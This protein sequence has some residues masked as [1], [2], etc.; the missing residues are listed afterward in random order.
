MYTA[1]LNSLQLKYHMFALLGYKDIG[2]R[3]FK[4]SGSVPLSNFVSFICYY[5][6]VLY[7]SEE[8]FGLTNG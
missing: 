4:F 3:K 8:L 6:S 7:F 1:R 5:G 2:I